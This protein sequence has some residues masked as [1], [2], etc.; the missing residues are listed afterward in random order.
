MN[1]VLKYFL[2]SQ[3]ILV[4]ILLL[5]RVQ[6]ETFIRAPADATIVEVDGREYIQPPLSEKDK[7]EVER[8]KA[9]HKK[10]KEKTAKLTG[11]MSGAKKIEAKVI[12]DN[13]KAIAD[14]VQKT[15]VLV[16]EG[17]AKI[18]AAKDNLDKLHGMSL[19]KGNKLNKDIAKKVESDL[20]K[21]ESDM[22]AAEEKSK[23]GGVKEQRM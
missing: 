10:Q 15:K 5:S 2:I 19:E 20:A 12:A 7:G 17:E 23:K 16:K 18:Q 22:R 4:I 9:E 21:A 11:V 3:I 14:A 13:T 1:V 6:H 8:I